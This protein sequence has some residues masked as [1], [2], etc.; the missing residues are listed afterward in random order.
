MRTRLFYLEFR[1]KCS[2]YVVSDFPG[3][4]QRIGTVVA[5][6]VACDQQNGSMKINCSSAL[7]LQFNKVFFAAVFSP[8]I[9]SLGSL[10]FEH[11]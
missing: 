1:E 6:L 11:Q 2:E 3:Q 8:F 10:K 9:W 5:C 4:M 7:C